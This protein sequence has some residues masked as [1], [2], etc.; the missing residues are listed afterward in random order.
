MSNSSKIEQI[1]ITFQSVS[2][3]FSAKKVLR[4]NQIKAELIPIPR[5]LSGSCEGLAA[6][7]D[8][9][10]LQKA[11]ALLDSNGIIV[12]KRGIKID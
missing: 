6:R 11:L 1:V 12:L 5:Q 3:A 10:C 7:I 8:Q 9:N 2:H 4:E